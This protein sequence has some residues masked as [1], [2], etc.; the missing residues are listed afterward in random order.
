MYKNIVQR[1]T[2]TC[3]VVLLVIT[4]WGW[5][6]PTIASSQSPQFNILQSE[7]SQIESRLSRIEL[8]LNQLRNPRSSGATSPPPP[9]KPSRNQPPQPT[10]ET[11]EQMFDRLATL[12]VEL[13][14][15]VNKLEVRVSKLESRGAPRNPR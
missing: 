3:L 5:L 10:L 8:Q 15:Q 12:V 6:F 1:M 11:R 13:K 7:V 2:L 14:Q 4:T 9:S